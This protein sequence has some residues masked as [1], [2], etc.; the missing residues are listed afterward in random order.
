MGF[1]RRELMEFLDGLVE[2]ASEEN[3]TRAVLAKERFISDFEKTYGYES[4][5]GGR[6]QNRRGGGRIIGILYIKKI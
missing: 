6:K 4:M 1:T 3:K 2:L 5:S